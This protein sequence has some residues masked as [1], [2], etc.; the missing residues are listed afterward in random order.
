MAWRSSGSTNDEMVNNLKRFGVISSMTVEEGFRNVDRKFFVPKSFQDMAYADQPL[1]EGN[2]H[3]SAPHIYGSVL[4]ALELR[5]N[6][7]LSFLNVGSGTGYLT[8]IAATVL[9]P[10]SSHFCIEVHEDV[11][12]HCRDAITSWKAHFPGGQ[13]TRQL[14]IL[15]GDAL[16]IE[17]EKGECALG[18]DRIYIGAAVSKQNLPKFKRLLKPGGVL[19]GPVEDELVKVVRTQ[20]PPDLAVGGDCEFKHQVLSGVRFSPLISNPRLKTVIPA[21][22]WTP[23]LHKFYPDSFQQSSKALFLCSRANYNQHIEPP[24]R[25]KVNAAS[26]L[27]RALW[28]EIL[29]YTHRDW[30]EAP[31]S[32][33][34]FLRQRLVEEKAKAERANSLRIEAETRCQMAEKE[35]EVYRLLAC[36]WKSHL[37]STLNERE[38]RGLVGVESVEEAAAAILFGGRD[39]GARFGLGNMLQRFHAHTQAFHV[40]FDE[41]QVDED[42]EENEEM[43]DRN[44]VE[45]SDEED[46]QMS[47]DMLD[48]ESSVS[49][50]SFQQNAGRGLE[51]TR[52]V[53]ATAPPNVSTAIRGRAQVRK[54]SVSDADL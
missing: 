51:T 14:K 22:L 19:V 20:S 21:R 44:E 27:P 9:G 25:K 38:V 40:D 28:M 49:S 26:L 32:E 4:E 29:S 36:R 10:R 31:Q 30:F 34:E 43:V 42:D 5:P 7:S 37:S 16:E 47:E 33:I 53:I 15:H 50:A 48:D 41:D 35:R 52:A 2:V 23:S 46:E 11:I 17:S 3:M 6:S 13:D 8:C 54:V 39:N 24:P 45:A 1:K 18:F 12:E